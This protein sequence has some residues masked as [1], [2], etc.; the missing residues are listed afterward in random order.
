MKVNLD[1]N[2]KNAVYIKEKNVLVVASPGSGKTT[3]IINRVNHLIEDL[4][5]NEGNI[6]V[7]TFT[8][9]AADNMRNRYKITLHLNT[10][11]FQ[12]IFFF[13]Y[14]LYYL[15]N[16]HFLTDTKQR[17]KHPRE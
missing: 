11:N 7:I 9:A 13:P 6:I 4:K 16:N 1:I 8:R 3:V 15:V 2:Q 14:L 5:I 17:E 12:L 10:C